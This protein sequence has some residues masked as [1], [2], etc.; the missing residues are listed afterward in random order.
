MCNC[1]VALSAVSSS[2]RRLQVRLDQLDLA[3]GTVALCGDR[4]WAIDKMRGGGGLTL[5]GEIVET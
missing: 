4:M 1:Q 3:E 2:I 5:P